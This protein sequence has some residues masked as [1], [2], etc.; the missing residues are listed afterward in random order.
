MCKLIILLLDK[1]LHNNQIISNGIVVMESVDISVRMISGNV[2][3][4]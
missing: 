3:L 1:Y 4:T 2:L